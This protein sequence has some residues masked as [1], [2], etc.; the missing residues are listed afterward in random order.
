MTTR[1]RP[2]CSSR[3]WLTASTVPPGS[4]WFRRTPLRR[5]QE[6]PG[7]CTKGCCSSGGRGRRRWKKARAATAV[8]PAGRTSKTSGT[9]RTSGIRQAGRASQAAAARRA[10]ACLRRGWRGRPMGRSFWLKT[11]Q[12]VGRRDRKA[13]R[14]PSA[15]P[16]PPPVQPAMERASPIRSCDPRSKLAPNP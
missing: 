7:R 5:K 8:N 11:D 2:S 10:R 1:L 9:G 16:K 4:P 6:R 3:C 14:S 12:P 13:T 15:P